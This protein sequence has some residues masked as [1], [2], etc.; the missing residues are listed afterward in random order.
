MKNVKCG[1]IALAWTSRAGLETHLRGELERG[2]LGAL[3]VRQR[4]GEGH[5]D[6]AVAG[7]VAV[8]AHERARLVEAEVLLHRVLAAA[9]RLVSGPAH[10][11]SP[12][13]SSVVAGLS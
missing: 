7:R 6:H 4:E 1:P 2:A 13:S 8:G 12:L 9:L 10:R 11:V 5:L 3:V